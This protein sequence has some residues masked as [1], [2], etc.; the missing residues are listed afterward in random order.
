MKNSKDNAFSYVRYSV[1]KQRLSEFGF[2]MATSSFILSLIGI[3]IICIGISLL[4]KL[5][6]AYVGIVTIFFLFCTPI[7]IVYRYKFMF[8][9]KK[10]AEVTLYLQQLAY[11]F[12]RKNKLV[13]ALQEVEG[14]T[15][16]RLNHKIKEALQYISIGEFKEDLYKEAL[17][18]IEKE[19]NCSRIKTLHS[20]IVDVERYGGKYR[21]TLNTLIV[22]IESWITRT[23]SYQE[24]RNGIKKQTAL[25][26]LMALGLCLTVTYMLPSEITDSIGL[27]TGVPYQLMTAITLIM[28]VV[29][30]IVVQ[31]KTSSSWLDLEDVRDDYTLEMINK[32]YEIMSNYNIKAATTKAIIFS[33]IFVVLGICGYIFTKFILIIPWVVFAALA[34]TSHP[35]MKKKKAKKKLLNEITIAFPIWIRGLVLQLQTNNVQVSLNKSLAECPPALKVEVYRLIKNIQSD[36][37]TQRPYLLF[38]EHFDA[39]KLKS[40]AHSLYGM[41]EFG[42]EEA[43]S[44]INSIISRNDEVSAIAEK[45][46]DANKISGL[47]MLTLAPMLLGSMNM[48]ASLFIFATSFFSF[49]ST[50]AYL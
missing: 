34:I 20:F 35:Y 49:F 3:A 9:Q 7:L 24:N 27:Y 21:R 11:A 37:L 43:T 18:I 44:Q 47:K 42:Q 22:D 23:M 12:K 48:F 2:S 50:S 17:S 31:K 41:S 16:G 6:I 33:S 39:Y 32:D 45:L 14:L 25:S 38:L 40:I 19:Y 30:Y 13:N 4:F 28:F 1:M 29:F 10:F 36:P 26:I 8:Q 5:K 15:T 46:A